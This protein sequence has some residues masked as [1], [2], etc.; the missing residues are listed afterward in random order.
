MEL[1]F[2]CGTCEQ[3]VYHYCTTTYHNRHE[4]STVRKMA[5]KNRAEL[6]DII[7]PVEETIGELSKAH[8]NVATTR[9]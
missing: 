8:Q 7:K 4:H 6:D 9:E 2:Y 1:N 3:L 5:N